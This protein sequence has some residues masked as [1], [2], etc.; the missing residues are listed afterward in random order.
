[1]SALIWIM[2]PYS[3]FLSFVLGHVWRLQHDG[4]RRYTSGTGLDR[5]ERFGATAFGLAVGLLVVARLT[6]L[7]ASGPHTY[8]AGTVRLAITVIEILAVA[9]A[10]IGATLLLVPNL[11][12]ATAGSPITPLDRVTFPLLTAGLLS[13]VAIHVDPNSDD[14]RY[15]SAETLFTWF[16]SLFTAHPHVEM[17][18]HAPLLYQTRALILLL[19]IAIWPYTRLAGTFARPICRTIKHLAS[20]PTHPARA[21]AAPGG[22]R[23]TQAST[24]QRSE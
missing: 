10:I 11:I 9:P 19:L 17:M 6:D 24:P 13:R 1:M 20:H 14:S 5:A 22:Y 2:L 23:L 18:Q 12:T 16:R 7:A 21:A 4:F 15:R 8:P 3:A